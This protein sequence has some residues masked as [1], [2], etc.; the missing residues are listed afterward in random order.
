MTNPETIVQ[1]TASY[2]LT[3]HDYMPVLAL[4]ELLCTLVALYSNTRYGQ[5]LL[6]TRR[7]VVY[8]TC[9]ISP[10]LSYLISYSLYS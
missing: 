6:A 5:S 4:L 10:S 3:T 7:I 1:L 2:S 9:R 8:D